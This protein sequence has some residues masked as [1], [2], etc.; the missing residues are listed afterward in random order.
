MN[1]GMGEQRTL[2]ETIR[3]L[4]SLFK[5]EAR[6]SYEPARPGE[7]RHSRADISLARSVLG[8][9]P[10]ISFEEGLRRSIEWYRAN[11]H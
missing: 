5:R 2:N 1:I 9:E 10:G 8:Y 3:M 11:V 6:P 4:N 7:V